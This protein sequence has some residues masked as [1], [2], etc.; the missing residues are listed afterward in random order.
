M[1]IL[2]F[3]D[4]HGNLDMIEHVIRANPLMDYYISLGDNEVDIKYLIDY[5]IISVIGNSIRDY[6]YPD[7]REIVAE[8]MLLFI[9]HGHK[10]QV[11]KSLKRLHQKA[12]N[13]H[14]NVVFYGHTHIAKIDNKQGVYIVNPG[15]VSRPRNTLPP[16]YLICEIMGE[17]ISFTFKDAV[18]HEIIEFN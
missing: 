6:G 12:K 1:K 16:T 2:V 3:S 17:D 11:Q 4:A 7:E 8:D 14:Y 5:N 15:S 18:T 13:N 9:T 10:Y